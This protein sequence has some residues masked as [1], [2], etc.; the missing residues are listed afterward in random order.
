MKRL[1]FLLLFLPFAL[2]AQEAEEHHEPVFHDHAEKHQLSLMLGHIYVPKAVNLE[3]E[4]SVGVALPIWS[5]GYNYHLK[6][7]WVLG[8]HVDVTVQSFEVRQSKDEARLERSYPI[9]PVFVVGHR[10]FRHG[11][12]VVGGGYELETHE[13]FAVARAGFEWGYHFLEHMEVSA[14]IDYDY[15]FEAYDSFSLM[16]G[17]SYLW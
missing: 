13:N 8:L 10:V 16:F 17:V 15:R 1:G 9:A 7:E 11:V 4:E 14:A 12:I 5:L 6:E 3:N 2:L